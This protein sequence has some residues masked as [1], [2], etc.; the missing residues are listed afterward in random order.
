M[1]SPFRHSPDRRQKDRHRN[2]LIGWNNHMPKTKQG[3]TEQEHAHADDLAAPKTKVIYEVVRR[4]GEE[5]LARPP[6]SLFWSGTAAGVAIMASVIAEASLRR[7]LPVDMPGRLA[8][9]DLG[10]SV[11]FLIV[12]LGRMQL[13]TEQTIVTVLPN[14]AAPGWGKLVTTA[15]LWAIVLAANLLGTS[16][17][18]WINLH[19]QLV[20]PDLTAS[21]LEVS[22]ELLG[23]APL[24]ILAHAIPA[25]FIMASVAWIRAGATDGEFWI[26]LA[27]TFF[28]ALGGFSHVV[29]GSAETFLLLFDGQIEV[30]H[31]FG[32]IIGP[33]LV[34]NVIGGT[35]LFAL[36]AHAQVSREI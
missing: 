31:A 29:A 23:Q 25:G 27:L 24:E 30:A 13:F 22:G 2:A 7:K 9:S 36:L 10:Y 1:L 21:M 26:V 3:L 6:G 32:G 12:I 5:E 18:A 14:M 8:I 4:Q 33:A 17:A 19:L 15:R 11:G 34:G 16:A 28:I 20:G 35:G